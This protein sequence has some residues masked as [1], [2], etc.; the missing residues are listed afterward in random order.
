MGPSH[1]AQRKLPPR[2]ALVGAPGPPI[3]VRTSKR[4]ARP[5]PWGTISNHVSAPLRFESHS[6]LTSGAMARQAGLGHTTVRAQLGWLAR[7]GIVRAV[8]SHFGRGPIEM[9]EQALR[10][11]LAELAVANPPG[12]A[13]TAAH[14]GLE[15]EIG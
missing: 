7:H 8:F 2:P 3:P 1:V 15:M 11:A 4:A 12:C 9:G 5:T 14:D 10:G 6:E 13:V